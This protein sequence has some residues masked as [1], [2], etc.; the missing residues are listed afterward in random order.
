ML[1]DSTPA[2]LA[3][4]RQPHDRFLALILPEIGSDA[5]SPCAGR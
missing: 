4:L 1:L 2:L 3:I 5:P